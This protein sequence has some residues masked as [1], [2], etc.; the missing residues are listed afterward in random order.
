M[1]FVLTQIFFPCI[2]GKPAAIDNFNLIKH[3]T[4]LM[5]IKHFQTK[6]PPKL[7]DMCHQLKNLGSVT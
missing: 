3:S 7:Q 5:N 6:N 1:A 4:I 2:C